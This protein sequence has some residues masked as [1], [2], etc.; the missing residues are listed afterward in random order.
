M[1][2]R[3]V[4]YSI[5]RAAGLGVWRWSV[6]VGQPEMLRLG[7]A[8]TEHRAEIEVRQ[9]IDRALD[10]QEALLFLN[11]GRPPKGE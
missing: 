1:K 10:V 11:P 3:G 9:V 5:V 7:D 4:N 6:L 2:Y 8:E